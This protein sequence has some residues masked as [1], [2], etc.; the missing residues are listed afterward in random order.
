VILRALVA[1][2]FSEK[3]AERMRW[4][5]TGRNTVQQVP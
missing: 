4:L 1:S 2:D 5:W 3:S